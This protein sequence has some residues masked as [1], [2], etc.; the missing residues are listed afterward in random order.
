MSKN[1]SLF[2]LY[3]DEIQSIREFM[4]TYSLEN[5]HA[6]LHSTDAN[7]DPDV[8]R[9]LESI[10][11]FSARTHENALRHVDDYRQRLY[12]QLFSY[13]ITPLPAFGILKANHTASM[14]APVFLER[15]TRLL[16]R[17]DLGQPFLFSLRAPLEIYPFFLKTLESKPLEPFGFSLTL[18]FHCRYTQYVLPESLSIYFDYIDDVMAS[19]AILGLFKN[20]LDRIRLRLHGPGDEDA[21]DGWYTLPEPSFGALK[22]GIEE[23]EFL[24]PMEEERLFFSDPRGDLFMHLALP[25]VDE[26]FDNF[27][28]DFEFSERWP[29]GL[30][31]NVD[32]FNLHCVP[33]VNLHRAM[34]SPIMADGTLSRF[35]I[36]HSDPESEFEL[37]KPIGV[38]K[39]EE[40]GTAPLAAGILG[41]QEGSYEIDSD[42]HPTLDRKVSYLN[43]HLPSAFFEPVPIFVDGLWH[44]PQ[45]FKNRERA[46]EIMAFQRI[47]HGVNWSWEALPIDTTQSRQS[48]H[49]SDEIL[50]ILAMSHKR[51]YSFQDL[52]TILHVYGPLQKGPMRQYY[53][54]FKDSRHELRLVEGSRLT[55]GYVIYFLDFEWESMDSGNE[56]FTVFLQ[57]F[58]RVLNHWTADREIRL[59][60]E[61][62]PDATA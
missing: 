12:R 41:D 40:S 19:F 62:Q 38:F 1:E 13:L 11:F 30:V 56:L 5:R 2:R 27:V 54:A 51:Y 17:T 58:E 7:E 16:L 8:L 39:A 4:A 31:P 53:A 29:K 18:H 23:E 21:D 22:A 61:S 35:P 6:G 42:T 36:L 55:A 50:S 57:H 10:A 28:I 3:Q 33:V 60:L 14:N 47:I 15:G 44:Q 20:K 59:A 45:F 52:R 26:P 43:L 25:R 24:H 48:G 32:L 34:S 37:V 49:G 46:S 9:L